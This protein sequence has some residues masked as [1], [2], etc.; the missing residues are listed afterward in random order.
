MQWWNVTR[1]FALIITTN[2]SKRYVST[3]IIV[4]TKSITAL[5]VFVKPR[6]P[7]WRNE[8]VIIRYYVNKVSYV[9]SHNQII[10]DILD[11][12]YCNIASKMFNVTVKK[13]RLRHTGPELLSCVRGGGRWCGGA[14]PPRY[15]LF[16]QVDRDFIRQ[17]PDSEMYQDD[18]N[19]FRFWCHALH[20]FYHTFRWESDLY[21][22]TV[23]LDAWKMSMVKTWLTFISP[24][25][26]GKRYFPCLIR[27]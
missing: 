6:H 15:V 14:I 20:Q 11:I 19:I 27:Y 8:D 23:I 25:F 5:H 3:R 24:V 26:T 9:R 2:W 22:Y 17:Q 7:A 12:L 4:L 1:H 18:V 13:L 10:L 21:T 16:V